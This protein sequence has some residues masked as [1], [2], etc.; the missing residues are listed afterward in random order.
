MREEECKARDSAQTQG[1]WHSTHTQ[2]GLDKGDKKMG[3][4][5]DKKR[6]ND[7]DKVNAW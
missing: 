4:K 3:N 1:F 2:N 7:I 6:R 5:S